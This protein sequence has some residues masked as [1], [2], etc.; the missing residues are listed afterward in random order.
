MIEDYKHLKSFLKEL[1]PF[2]YELTTVEEIQVN[3]ISTAVIKYRTGKAEEITTSLNY[4]DWKALFNYLKNIL[5]SSETT[6]K[7]NNSSGDKDVVL[8]E[9]PKGHRFN[10]ILA[11]YVRNEISVAIRVNNKADQVTFRDFN[12]NK[13]FEN[14]LI[15]AMIAGK[16]I[17]ISGAGGS[18]KTSLINLLIKHIPLNE[19][20]F[21]IEDVQE[22]DIPHANKVCMLAKGDNY[23]KLIDFTM[24]GTPDRIFLGEITIVNAYAVEKFLVNGHKGFL[25][26]VHG[27]SAKEALTETLYSKLSPKHRSIT[28][29]TD[30]VKLLLNNVDLVFQLHTNKATN[31]RFITEIFIVKNNAHF[32]LLNKEEYREFDSIY[33]NKYHPINKAKQIENYIRNNKII[34]VNSLSNKFKI[35][36]RFIKQ[37]VPK[38]KLQKNKIL[39]LCSKYFSYNNSYIKQ[40]LQD[41]YNLVVTTRR[42]EQVKK[43]LKE[44]GNT[45]ETASY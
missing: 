37:K 36:Y 18:G 20:I 17:I 4:G 13:K 5:S 15:D 3:N 26:T 45:N 14:F 30:L 31:K 35:P 40:K 24:K 21:A 38:E 19:R 2:L 42:L 6:N 8:I 44:T 27:S 25:A 12:I 22:L 32:K 11:K 29:Q 9:L 7:N 39:E 28:K 43:Q 16:T 1:Y 34:N 33:L 23:D 10:G 41:E